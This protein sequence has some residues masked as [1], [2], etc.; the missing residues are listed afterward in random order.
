ML[1]HMAK[2]RFWKRKVKEPTFMELLEQYQE[3]C[4]FGD[5]MVRAVSDLVRVIEILCAELEAVRK[6]GSKCQQFKEKN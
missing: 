1:K 2:F 5:K 6:D 3:S 4:E